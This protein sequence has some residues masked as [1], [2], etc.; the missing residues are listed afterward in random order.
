MLRARGES[1]PRF[2]GEAGLGSLELRVTACRLG[3]PSGH[4]SRLGNRDPFGPRSGVSSFPPQAA[5]QGCLLLSCISERKREAGSSVTSAHGEK[6][7][8]EG[9]SSFLEH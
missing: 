2:M 3:F 6:R 1:G 7:V 9:C 8:E 4:V 5:V